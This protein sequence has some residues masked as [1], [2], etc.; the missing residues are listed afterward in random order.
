MG[1]AS[2]KVSEFITEMLITGTVATLIKREGDA[3]GA[4]SWRPLHTIGR[5]IPLLEVTSPFPSWLLLPLETTATSA[6]G[7]AAP[8]V[9]IGAEGFSAAGAI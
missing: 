7:S 9:N 4:V 5:V 8:F 3:I 2:A 1:S 6:V